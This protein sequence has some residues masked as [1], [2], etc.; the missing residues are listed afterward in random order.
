MTYGT[1]RGGR[2]TTAEARRPA[3][4]HPNAASRVATT[5]GGAVTLARLFGDGILTRWL[6]AILLERDAEIVECSA[7]EEFIDVPLGCY[8]LVV[9]CTWL[10]DTTDAAAEWAQI[11]AILPFEEVIDLP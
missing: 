3:G 8:Q 2:A 11:A 4:L 1:I 6:Q 5:L 10:A 9:E 7:A